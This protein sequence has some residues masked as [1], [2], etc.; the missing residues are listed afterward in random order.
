MPVREADFCS[1][2]GNLLENAVRAAGE[3]PPENRRVRA[4][5]RMLS[6]A[7]MGLSVENPCSRKIP[8]KNGLPVS[9]REGHGIGLASVSATVHR[10]GG[11]LD[12]KNEDG[13]FSV[14]ILLCFPDPAK[15]KEGTGDV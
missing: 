7:M 8:M 6:D 3:E 14:N 2:L 12:I 10:Y 13:L 1:I 9:D 11:S 4:I 5:G 15:R